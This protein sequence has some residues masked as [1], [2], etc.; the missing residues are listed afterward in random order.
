MT[1][2]IKPVQTPPKS[3][4]GLL[5]WYDAA[6]TATITGTTTVTQWAD[7]SGNGYHLLNTH[8]A[9]PSSGSRTHNGRNV[10]D[11]A[12]GS[13]GSAQNLSLNVG[14]PA[15]GLPP[16]GGAYT[17]IGVA[18][19]DSGSDSALWATTKSDAAGPARHT[20]NLTSGNATL[21]MIDDS[22]VTLGT[23]NEGGQSNG[24]A[25]L[26]TLTD[27]GSGT[28]SLSLNQTAAATGSWTNTATSANCFMVGA[29]RQSIT[30]FRSLDG[31]IAELIFW[32]RVL[33]APEIAIVEAY[34][35]AK[36]NV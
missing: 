12:G 34:L 23:V 13:A 22:S 18:L 11:F 2:F 17:F 27:A 5:Q 25:F 6:D 33:T 35:K 20:I 9:Q 30:Q 3:I 7:K 24:S 29:L 10:L 32:N 8:G 21:E 19:R 31:F 16:D 26:C 28:K 15:S 1:I 4:E 14:F 36:W